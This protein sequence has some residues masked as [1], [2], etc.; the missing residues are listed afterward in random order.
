[1]LIAVVGYIDSSAVQLF[2]LLGPCYANV[3]HGT[4][5]SGIRRNIVDW[6]KHLD[7]LASAM[8]GRRFIIRV[9]QLKGVKPRITG[10]SKGHP[11]V[12][13]SVKSHDHV[14]QINSLMFIVESTTSFWL[15]HEISIKNTNTKTMK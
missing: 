4:V 8:D 12:L 13:T 5:H 9:V 2:G 1:M 6:L 14:T 15:A 7:Q 3:P 10:T 11:P